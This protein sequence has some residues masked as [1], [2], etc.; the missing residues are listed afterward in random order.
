MPS[1]LFLTS[2]SVA[3]LPDAL[4]D[5]PAIL[6][7]LYIPTAMRVEP[8]APA[9][10]PT[11][12]ALEDLGFQIDEIDIATATPQRVSQAAA[13]CDVI[14]LDGGN[15]Y[16]LLHHI[17][18]SG[19]REALA[20]RPDVVYAGLS[21]GAIVA[22]P[23]ISFIGTEADDPAVVPELESTTGLGLVDFGVLPHI[24]HGH[25]GSIWERTPE[26]A[27]AEHEIVKLRDDQA[28]IV[29][30]GAREVVAS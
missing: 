12:L 1:T 11:K 10:S 7:L 28:V 8:G 16:Y 5:P 29:K 9:V 17:N 2:A 24:D 4:E 21:A 26:I 19:L 30:N 23:D 18:R 22:G 13:A 3:A 6:Q 27:S 15:T 14:F 20:S 25:F